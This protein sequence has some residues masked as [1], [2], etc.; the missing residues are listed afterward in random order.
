MSDA[1]ALLGDRATSVA[2]GRVRVLRAGHGERRA[3]RRLHRGHDRVEDRIRDKWK[4]TTGGWAR[5]ATSRSSTVPTRSNG[6]PRCTATLDRQAAARGG[7]RRAPPRPRRGDVDAP[8]EDAAGPP[9]RTERSA[10]DGL[11]RGR[12]AERARWRARIR[13]RSRAASRAPSS[14]RSASTSTRSPSR[15]TSTSATRA[16]G[17]T[18]RWVLARSRSAASARANEGALTASARSLLRGRRRSRS[19]ARSR[20]RASSAGTTRRRRRRRCARGCRRCAG[21]RLLATGR[22][23][24]SPSRFPLSAR[25][26]LGAPCLLAAARKRGLPHFRGTRAIAS[27]SRCFEAR[28]ELSAWRHDLQPRSARAQKDGILDRR[29]RQWVETSWRYLGIGRSRT[30]GSLALAKRRRGPV[31]VRLERY[32][33][34]PCARPGNCDSRPRKAKSIA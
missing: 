5:L 25:R 32:A 29:A 12:G 23:V 27:A 4:A 28:R 19:S 34:N 30:C 8:R 33:H 31:R 20:R 26:R 21:R 13:C 9:P 3:D 11:A 1:F 7:R 15:R 6:W 14:R 18:R 2:R 17:S 10:R 22:G 16:A 24:H